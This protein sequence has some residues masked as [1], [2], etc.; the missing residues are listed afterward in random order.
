MSVSFNISIPEGCF[1]RAVQVE[2][3]HDSAAEAIKAPCCSGFFRANIAGTVTVVPVDQT[4]AIPFVV[5]AG[6][7]IPVAIKSAY[8]DGT[9][10]G[11]IFG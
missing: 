2:A 1:T 3:T 5:A 11:V 4:N 10:T 7:T 9:V 8:S 6:D